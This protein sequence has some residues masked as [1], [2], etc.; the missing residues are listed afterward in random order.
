MAE[1][2]KL[3]VI[4][5]VLVHTRL[6]EGCDADAIDSV[7]AASDLITYEHQQ[8]VAR[9]GDS[10]AQVGGFWLVASGCLECTRNWANGRRVVFSFQLA[11]QMTCM[12][13]SL[14][15]LPVAFD[16]VARGPTQ[17]I[18]IPRF[19]FLDAIRKHPAL[20]F[21]VLATL[22]RRT[23]IDYE[24]IEMLALNG[25]RQKLAKQ[26]LYLAREKLTGAQGGLDIP[27]KISQE[28]VAGMLGVTRQIV[29]KEI[30]WFIK[31]GILER[32]YRSVVVLDSVRL[33]E[34][35]ESEEPFSP[36]VRQL[37]FVPPPDFYTTSD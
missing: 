30:N 34:V 16:V 19:A 36:T 14:D 15:D 13:P 6:F 3:D 5:S 21:S 33:L 26:L 28:D 20:A 17:A 1:K 2:S 9:C 8:V 25:M 23:R 37:L 12:L 7:C 27:F 32:H 31:A 35:A 22:G 29:N 10:A 11:G 4:R 18:F 24:R